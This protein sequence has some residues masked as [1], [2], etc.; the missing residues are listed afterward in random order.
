M[1]YW[2]YGNFN[3]EI[4][5]WKLS[6]VPNKK[7]LKSFSIISQVFHRSEYFFWKEKRLEYQS[8]LTRIIW[9]KDQR[10]KESNNRMIKESDNQRTRNQ[11]IKESKDP[12]IRDSKNQILCRDKWHQFLIVRHQNQ[13]TIESEN[14]KIKESNDQ[15]LKGSKPPWSN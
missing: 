6:S 7:C 9:P 13:R 2:K 3:K 5:Q 4:R 12:M 11:R 1:K 14:R 8:F 15:G 10:T